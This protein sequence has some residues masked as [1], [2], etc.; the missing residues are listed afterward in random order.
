ML[1]LLFASSVV[2]VDEASF[3]V[4]TVGLGLGTRGAIGFGGVAGL[5]TTEAGGTTVA[6]G[7]G[8]VGCAMGSLATGLF[9]TETSWYTAVPIAIAPPV[10]AIIPPI[11]LAFK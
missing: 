3:S 7:S 10:R 2:V 8:T 5:L 11:A 1:L 4:G 6:A 9:Q